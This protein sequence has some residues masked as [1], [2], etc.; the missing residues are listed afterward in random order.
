MFKLHLLVCLPRHL[1]LCGI[2]HILVIDGL[3]RRDRRPCHP[4][5]SPGGRNV[6]NDLSSCRKV[7][8]LPAGP[9]G[10]VKTGEGVGEVVVVGEGVATASRVGAR[11]SEVRHISSP[12]QEGTRSKYTISIWSARQNDPVILITLGSQQ[13]HAMKRTLRTERN[14]NRTKYCTILTYYSSL[15][16]RA[17]MGFT[18]SGQRSPVVSCTL[19]TQVWVLWTD[20]STVMALLLP[21]SEKK[22]QSSL[23]L[24]TLSNSSTLERMGR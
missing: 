22:S 13:V 17:H 4:A 9:E 10:F 6:S 21:V 7:S 12:A 8:V 24:L 18:T 16:M 5:Q 14:K 15:R 20:C 19:S 3:P 11:V 23:Y 1:A 2:D